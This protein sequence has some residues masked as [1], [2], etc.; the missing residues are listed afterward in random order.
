MSPLCA[1][2]LLKGS[3][4]HDINIPVSAATKFSFVI[5]QDQ[6]DPRLLIFII[7]LSCSIN[8]V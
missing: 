3:L 1:F 2:E 8:F 4:K 7:L 6:R 5:L